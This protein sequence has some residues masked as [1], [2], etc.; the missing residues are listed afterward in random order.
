LLTESPIVAFTILVAVIFIVPPIF[1][2]L[3]L[4]GLVGL[5]VAG[6]ILGQNGLKLLDSESETIKLLSEIGKVYLMFVAGLEIDLEQ[7]RQTKNKSIGFGTLTFLVPLVAGIAV[8]RL[9][10]FS[11]NASVLIGSLLASHTLLAYP[12]V[13]R[14]GVVTNEAVTVTIG[15]TI[16]TDT[17]A[18]LVLAICVG[19]HQGEF[20]AVSLAALL[21]GLV[22]YAAVVLFGFDWAGKEYFRRTGDEEGN[23]FLFIL[24]ALFIASVGAQVIGVEKIVGAFLAGLAVNDVLGNSRVKEKIEF[25]GSVLFIPCFFVDMGLLIDLPA[26][27]KTLSSVWLTAAIVAAL[28]GSKFLAAFFAKL[29]YRYN[30][31][32]LLTMWSL[33]LPQVAATL[34]AALVAYET[35]NPAGDRLINEGVLNSVIVLMLVTAI[36]GPL[37]TAR[38]ASNLVISD[39]DTATDSFSNWWHK[40]EREIEEQTHIPFTVVV[41]I[42][43]PQTQRYLLEMAAMLARHESG[44][45]VPLAIA[46]AGSHMDDPQLTEI[47]DRTDERLQKAVEICKEFNVEALPALRID[48][49][50]ALGIGRASR[51]KNA[52]LVVMGWGY[53][54][55]FRSRLFGNLIDRVFLSSHCPVAVTR[56][57]TSPS[58]IRTILVPVDNLT[59]RAIATVRFAQILADTNHAEI[60]LL[61]VCD[62]RTP[63]TQIQTFES[64]LS[65]IV[66]EGNL[67]VSPKIQTIAS[68]DVA[69]TIIEQAKNF[70]LVVLRSVR[71]RTAGGLAVSEVTTRVIK[72]LKGSI[73]LLGEP[74][75]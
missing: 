35:V 1:E 57:L 21:G 72:E 74:R 70:D 67:Q 30:K 50:I 20:T 56:L 36:L 63:R 27:V 28:I 9:F 53:A 6:V 46:K 12:I 22:I 64:Q 41:P 47:L 40:D 24:L 69:L 15:A 39:A 4:P 38:S 75:S 25:V 17:G 44:R 49:N 58:E 66:S 2:R 31:P 52:S 11:W 54:A 7:F 51:E 33:S 23:Q 45:I 5:L 26:F 43:N 65:E 19:I 59:R 62:R 29:L 3:R 37:I 61:H 14:L 42:Y 13:S 68:N 71:Y 16:F 10:D 32:E 48:D 73:V 18:L 8:G 55:G 34:A 60:V